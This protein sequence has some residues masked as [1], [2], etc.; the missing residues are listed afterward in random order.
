MTKIESLE[1]SILLW[2]FLSENPEL[3]KSIAISSIFPDEEYPINGCFLCEYGNNLK[4][5]ILDSMCNFCP[6]WNKKD[7]CEDGDS[8]YL[9][10]SNS[11]DDKDF[12]NVSIY[13]KE[14]A[15]LCREALKKEIS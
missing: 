8:P 4:A 11:R 5:N 10:W 6:V 9:A 14:V 15:N 7:N 2:D 1:K 3:S 12:E 13:A